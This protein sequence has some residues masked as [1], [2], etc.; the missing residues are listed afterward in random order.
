MDKLTGMVS[1]EFR[2]KVR[3]AMIR[4]LVWSVCLCAPILVLFSASA[5]AQGGF[6]GFERY[7]NNKSY[8]HFKVEAPHPVRAGVSSQRFELR[9]GDCGE[10]TGWND[11]E[12]D[13]ERIELQANDL[14]YMGEERWIGWSVF[15]P[16]DFA[17]VSPTKTCLG[18]IHSQGGPKGFGRGL[19][20][21]PPLLKFDIWEGVYVLTHPELSGTFHNIRNKERKTPLINLEQMRGRWTDIV[22][23]VRFGKEDGFAVV[24]VNGEKKAELPRNLILYEPK[25][26]VF[27]YGIY[28]SFM[29]RSARSI[30]TQIVYF[31]EVRL[32]E[33]RK[34][35]DLRMNSALPPVD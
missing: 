19:P 32:G 4:K 33:T 24:Y 3:M 17:D 7:L 18:Q 27:R 20:T 11:C 31:D 28:R 8:A 15:L 30:P 12:T 16:M 22:L 29:G 6:S 9:S 23:H 10:D 21:S 13:R 14:F 2:D 35:V 25:N 34:A 5:Q 26:F 1:S